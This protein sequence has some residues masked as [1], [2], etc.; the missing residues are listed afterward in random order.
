MAQL[1][2]Q[3]KFT[4]L[5][6]QSICRLY[7]ESKMTIPGQN[8]KRIIKIN[9]QHIQYIQLGFSVKWQTDRPPGKTQIKTIVNRFLNDE[10]L[11]LKRHGKFL[12]FK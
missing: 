8:T 1:E 7:H 9:N 2:A 12:L 10:P 11:R 3:Q 5:Q 4:E 6:L